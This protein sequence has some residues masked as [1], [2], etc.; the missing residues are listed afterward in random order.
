MMYFLLS[1][2]A[3]SLFVL[4]SVAVAG[5]V[6][7]ASNDVTLTLVS[8]VLTVTNTNDDAAYTI[9]NFAYNSGTN[10]VSFELT[11]AAVITEALAAVTVTGTQ[12]AQTVTVD[13]A[14]ASVATAFAGLKL[15]SLSTKILNAQ[16]GV[17]GINLSSVIT[18]AANQGFNLSDLDST[19]D[20]DTFVRGALIAKGTGDVII[21]IG[22]NAGSV[23]TVFTEGDITATTG[24]VNIT[25]HSIDFYADV[26][27]AGPLS[28]TGTGSVYALGL[29]SVASVNAN[30]SGGNITLRNIVTTTG[31][32]I[33]GGSAMNVYLSGIIVS[34]GAFNIGAG[35]TGINISDNTQL[36]LNSTTLG[37][38]FASPLVVTGSGTFKLL[39]VGTLTL[40]ADSS[41]G[42]TE[43]DTINVTNATL[44]VTGKLGSLSTVT[45]TNGTLTGPGGTVGTLTLGS[46]TVIPRGTLN[47]AAVSFSVPTTYSVGV[48]TATTASNLT[49]ASAI[50]LGGA[51]LTVHEVA[52]GL[53][54]NNSF[55][56][57]NNTATRV[58]TVAGIF[59]GLPQGTTLA[60]TDTAGNAVIVQI[61]YVGGDGNDVTLK[62]VGLAPNAPTSVSA[63]AG[64]GQAV[65]SFTAPEGAVTSYTVT[66]TPVG[67][68]TAVI[69]SGS[70]SPI[71]VTGLTNGTAYTFTVKAT[72]SVGTGSASTASS[73]VIPVTVPGAPTAV[74][75][76]SGNTQAVV[77]F[78]APTSNGGATIT[79][80]TVT[81]TPPD[82]GAAVTATGS[83]SPI[84][85]TGLTNGTAYTFAVTATNSVGASSA[86]SASSSVIPVTVP[87]APTAVSG[88]SS[89]TQAV[90]QTNYLSANR[91]FSGVQAVSNTDLLQTNLASV[92]RTG[93]SGSGD[94]YFFREDGGYPVDLSRLTNGSF[95]ELSGSSGA[96]VFPNQVTLTFV[97]RLGST[98]TSIR[99]F[100][101][102]GDTGRDGQAYTVQYS[103]VSDP[104]NFITLAAITRYDPQESEFPAGPYGRDKTN[105]S[106]MVELTSS[107]GPLAVNVAAIRF[108]FGSYDTNTNAFENGGSAYREI[109]VIGSTGATTVIA[110]NSQATLTFTA[111]SD[112]GGASITSYTIT[113]TPVGGGTA[114]TATGSTSPITVTG[115]TNGTAYTFSATATNRVG[116][117][118]ASSV[119]GMLTPILPVAITT[120]PINLTV[121]QGYPASFTVAASGTVPLS[122]QW[123]KNNVAISGATSATY[124]I[125][126]VATTD[127]GSYTVTITNAAGS[128]T[129]SAATLTVQAFNVL[130]ANQ[131]VIA[132]KSAA[133]T[134]GVNLGSTQW[135][136]S[137]DA[138]VTWTNLSSS[139]TYDGVTTNVLEILKVTT[140]MSKNRYRYQ[141]TIN[142]QTTTSAPGVITV[143]TAF[144]LLPVGVQVDAAGNLYVSDAAGQTVRKIS[145]DFKISTLTGNALSQGLSDGVATIA[146]L[147]EPAGLVL[148]ADNSLLLADTGNAALRQISTVGTVT[149]FAGTSGSK[150]STDATGTAARFSAPVGLARDGSGNYYVADQT[151]HTIRKISA[152][153]VVTTLAGTAG[154]SGSVDGTGTTARFNLPTGITCNAQGDLYVSDLGSHL[155]RKITAAGVVTTLAGQVN[156]SGS[157]DGSGTAAR[158]FKPAGLAIDSVGNVYVADMGNSTLR[159]ISASGV[160]S[161]LAGLPTID[162]LMDG[163]GSNAWFAEPQALTLD[164]AGNIYVADTANAVLRKVTPEGL[165]TTLALAG[166][167]PLISAQPVSITIS[168]GGSANFSVSAVGEAPLSYQWKKDGADISGAVY[169]SYSVAPVTPFYAGNYTVAVTNTYGTSLS[170]T[171]TLTVE[172]SVPMGGFL[173]GPGTAG[174]GAVSSWFIGA[175]GLLL[176]AKRVRRP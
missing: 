9:N 2:L 112:N 132:G 152:S 41:A 158:F 130:T 136:I 80:Y 43:G 110:G 90:V 48:L 99:T 149:T 18:G 76:V 72:N 145:S 52:T 154:Q 148:N 131:N 45:L 21:N 126:T 93:A 34:G 96:S 100:A 137:T 162:G 168:S 53:A 91:I 50:N 174:G 146:K 156:V 47:T 29:V 138:G 37:S 116:T 104:T 89:N 74:S 79:S 51:T 85:V 61:S 62:I 39:G 69:A 25:G 6:H 4:F 151:N 13:L 77:S 78:T 65:V 122:Y 150:G 170:N 46:G 3:R 128:V 15:T 142:N 113:A 164:S 26:T 84:T 159:K 119:S 120:P 106:T 49:T 92:S 94:R 1:R 173:G 169:T 134:T 28:L 97:L 81:A 57:I 125:A 176:L 118:S 108:V 127:A 101:G 144:L 33:A 23:L 36:I 147:N 75:G 19:V 17:A 109:D 117:S 12:G 60:T 59:A 140:A 10:K 55:T 67:G 139:Y 11:G 166:T 58:V 66:A 63:L 71:T 27:S 103:A 171:A 163:T 35:L 73:S 124:T 160:V 20:N 102:W 8:G 56:I 54:V 16:V 105:P 82:G 155:I 165:V 24:A 157:S 42:V 30:S 32:T 175:L 31:A 161:T 38:T 141:V 88:V 143:G 5:S 22:T 172:G 83:T 121:A 44:K 129:S 135:Q 14:D 167:A 64:N 114:V 115:L 98:I 111:P 133:F 107:S 70:S 123:L 68:G 95:G 153:G 7:A 86:S 40:S 87:G